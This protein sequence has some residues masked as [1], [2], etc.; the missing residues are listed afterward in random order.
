DHRLSPLC[1]GR[2]VCFL[3]LFPVRSEELDYNVNSTLIDHQAQ[4]L[5]CRQ[6]KLVR[7]G[8]TTSEFPL[9]GLARFQRTNF[10]CVP[11]R[12]TRIDWLLK[13]SSEIS[14]GLLIPLVSAPVARKD[15]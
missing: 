9:D 6:R 2:A 7:M 15:N 11:R 5:I 12:I 14:E 1:A 10:L 13:L 4:I 3:H 8:L